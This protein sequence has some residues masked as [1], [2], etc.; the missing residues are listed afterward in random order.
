MTENATDAA[1]EEPSP[2]AELRQRVLLLEQALAEYIERYGL[3]D[4]AREAFQSP[5]L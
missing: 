3:T 5:R 2:E 4:K 1:C